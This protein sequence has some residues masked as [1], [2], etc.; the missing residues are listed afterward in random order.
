M[1]TE[2]L[3][4]QEKDESADE[5]QA[6][7]KGMSQ[8][9]DKEM[10]NDEE[11]NIYVRR[12]PFQSNRNGFPGLNKHLMKSNDYFKVIGTG[13]MAIYPTHILPYNYLYQ[14][15]PVTLYTEEKNS[16]SE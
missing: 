5:L 13:K 8:G 4:T 7:D 10:S 2:D 15:V 16:Q 1:Y 3:R 14:A 9:E 12:Y 11:D 6:E